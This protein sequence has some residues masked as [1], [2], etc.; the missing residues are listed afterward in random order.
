M[1][2]T[3][4]SMA[5]KSRLLKGQKSLYLIFYSPNISVVVCV[6]LQWL[7]SPLMVTCLF[8]RL[9]LK[10]PAAQKKQFCFRILLTT[11]SVILLVR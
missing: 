5:D 1:N 11:A 9:N 8:C 7:M 4:L 3:C 2:P 10:P 6:I